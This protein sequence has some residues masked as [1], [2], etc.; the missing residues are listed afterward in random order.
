MAS[1]REAALVRDTVVSWLR[2]RAAACGMAGGI[3][4]LS[5]GVDSA[6]LAALLKIAFGDAMLAVMLPCHSDPQDEEDARLVAEALA[7]PWAKVDLSAP[8]DALTRALEIEGPLSSLALANVKP[9]MRMT[10]LYALARDRRF[11]VCGA[12]NK[13]E[14]VVGYFTKHGDSGVDL[15]PM[16]DLVKGEVRALA[17]LLG[18]P[19]RIVEKPPTAGLWPGQTDEGEMGV[20]YDEL[21]EVILTGEGDG[22]AKNFV[23][24]ARSQSEHKRHMPP[25]CPIPS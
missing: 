20:R 16:G 10:V 14:W 12:T 6:V 9:R 7:L 13:D 15:L 3:V 21:D 22:A 23:A 4:G 8:Y 11:L 18:V 24:R 25:V 5:G 17:T 19:R 1:L 2:E